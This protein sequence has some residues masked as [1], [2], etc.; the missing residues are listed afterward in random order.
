[1]PDKVRMDRTGKEAYQAWI[2]PDKIELVGKASQERIVLDKVGLDG[3]DC[4]AWIVLD[5]VWLDGKA[6]S[7]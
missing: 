3:K 6:Y 7:V 5:K 1:M 4:L 2:V